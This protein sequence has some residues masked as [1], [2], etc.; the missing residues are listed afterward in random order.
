MAAIT[1]SWAAMA[2]AEPSPSPSPSPCTPVQESSLL[3]LAD[4]KLTLVFW[5][6]TE[7]KQDQS[8]A[9]VRL[10]ETV[11]EKLG[12]I[13][14]DRCNPMNKGGG[15][16][17][18]LVRLSKDQT[19]E[20][21]RER[22]KGVHIAIELSRSYLVQ[23]DSDDEETQ[24]KNQWPLHNIGTG[25]GGDACSADADIN[26]PE[27]WN[28]AG[29]DVTP[30]VAVA[31]I[32]T[33]VDYTHTDLKNQVWRNEKDPPDGIDNDNNGYI[34]DYYGLNAVTAAGLQGPYC[35]GDPM[36]T[37][38]H[39]THMAGIIAAEHGNQK[40]LKGVAP[41][42]RIVACKA[43]DKV[44]RCSTCNVVRCLDWVDGLVRDRS[45][46]IDLIATNNSY[47]MSTGS[48]QTVDPVLAA[49]ITAQRQLG[50]IFVAASGSTKSFSNDDQQQFPACVNEANVMSVA[51]TTCG[52]R[53]ASGSGWGPRTVHVSAPGDRTVV[54]SPGDR[55]DRIDGSSPAAAHVSGLLA[56]VR[57][58]DRNRIGRQKLNW[59]Q[60]KNLVIAG[61]TLA[62]E[63]LRG[64][65]I[66]G[67]RIRA[68]DPCSYGDA[69]AFEQCG[70]QEMKRA[71]SLSCQQQYVQRRLRPLSKPGADKVEQYVIGSA[72]APIPLSFLNISCADPK[73]AIVVSASNGCPGPTP[74]PSPIATDLLDTGTGPD[75]V[76]SDGIYAI[77][78]MMPSGWKVANLSFAEKSAPTEILD[79]LRICRDAACGCP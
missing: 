58:V 23:Q 12:I 31:V 2:A 17:I 39:G 5:D 40:F 50:V 60:L 33:G 79:Q 68:F 54:L 52:D 11:R 48:G 35:A 62:P 55:V 67:R 45:A 43:C 49:A 69:K 15:S 28:V 24:F 74:T 20:N 65:T 9:S 38:N 56:L 3:P 51:S 77:D 61:G 8:D 32:D 59:T 16:A 64:M 21:A 22:L 57:G 36:D 66:S 53:V 18:Y 72:T 4:E 41:H 75:Q 19:L 29:G 26:G 27:A 63:D 13:P 78:W 30:P 73:G 46:D 14:L 70:A 34:D 44:D 7:S 37:S 42:A 6:G 76:A 47:T 1:V 10:I 25:I 71:G